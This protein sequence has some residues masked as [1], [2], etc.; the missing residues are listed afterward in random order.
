MAVQ[1]GIKSNRQAH[2]DTYKAAKVS[3][4]VNEVLILKGEEKGSRGELATIKVEL[5]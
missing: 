3:R 1:A 4:R 5:V 2:Y